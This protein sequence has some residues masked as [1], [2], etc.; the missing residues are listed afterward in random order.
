MVIL[1]MSNQFYNYIA[2]LLIEHFN[3]AKI[4]PGD[5]Y[6]LQLDSQ[7]DVLNLVRALEDIEGSQK[8]KYKH[9]LGEEYE[10]FSLPF[11]QVNLVVAYTSDFVKPDF[12]VTLRNLAGEQKEK[13]ENTALISIVSEQLDSIE[14]GSSN[15]Q[16][17]GMPLHSESLF[18]QLK[19]DIENSVLE[20]VDQIIL[21][22]N[23]E[24]LM[25]EQPFQQLT[26]FD[27][28][29]IFA[30]LQK[31]S[32]EDKEYHKFGLFK[33]PDLASFKGKEQKERLKENREFFDY[34]R[35]VHELGFDKDELQKRFSPEGSNDLIGEDWQEILFPR[36]HKYH[37]DWKK[38]HKKK[39]IDL[40]G[41]KVADKLKFW[42]KPHKET[43]SGQR[44]RHII[45]FNPEEKDSVELEASFHLEGNV[46]SLSSEFLNTPNPFS[47]RVEAN[48]KVT[49]LTATIPVE[50]NAASF[51]RFSYKHDKKSSLGAEF[52]IAVLPIEPIYLDRYKSTYLI[53]PNSGYIE[54]QYEDDEL[55]FND[56]LEIK[57]VEISEENQ[58]V[59]V[60]QDEK[61]TIIPRPEAYNDN[62]ELRLKIQFDQAIVPILLRNELPESMPISGHRIWKL[63]RDRKSTRLNSSHQ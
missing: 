28:E 7:S 34:V 63:I 42:D 23:L 37:E 29:D 60:T 30:T 38:Q 11:N 8:F 24:N 22:D 18:I 46:K 21:L 48:V 39:K 26:F 47:K 3:E 17:E 2:S 13:W 32:I 58:L 6:Y 53:E 27:F 57:K 5:R 62:D 14:G 51:V 36:V 40:K 15:L 1:S 35:K 54:L 56:G 16:K 9:K 33:D 20:K 59:S 50:K 4:K 10:T 55:S 49:N 12:L 44:K 43:S 41:I 61:L 31:G 52:F 45:I 25:K 19:Q